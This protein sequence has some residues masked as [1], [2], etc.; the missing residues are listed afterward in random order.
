M[1]HRP[2]LRLVT[3]APALA[4]LA[5]L[6]LASAVAAASGGGDFPLWRR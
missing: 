1:L 3:L 6:L 5:Q 4:V 2:W